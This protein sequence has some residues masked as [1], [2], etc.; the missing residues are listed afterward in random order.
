MRKFLNSVFPF[1]LVIVS[2]AVVSGQP[3]QDRLIGRWRSTQVSAGV[4]AVFEFHDD[5]Q[6]DSYSAALSDGKYRLV[7][8]DTIVLQPGLQS[9]NREEKQELEW[10]SQDRGRIEDEAA[11]KSIELTRVGIMAD[12]KNP[13]TGEWST[14]REWMGTTYP[15]R[16]LFFPDGKVVWVTTLRADHGRYSIQNGNVRLE[17]SGRP[18]VEGRF[19]VTGDR[20]TLTNPRGGESVFERF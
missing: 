19:A 7:G 2:V 12:T 4:S 14:T 8:T 17:I 10:D 20:L 15:A 16:A 5:N 11:G 6:L 9:E 18:V 1:V 13:L 3:R